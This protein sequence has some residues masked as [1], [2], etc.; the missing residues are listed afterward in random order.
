MKNN[1]TLLRTSAFV[2]LLTALSFCT[3]AQKRQPKF[4]TKPFTNKVFI[5]ERGQFAQRA[6]EQGIPFLEKVMY[7]VENGEFYTY[8]N[9][10]GITFRFA[11]YKPIERDEEEDA[12]EEREENHEESEEEE[13]EK[14]KFERVWHTVNLKFVNANPLTEVVAAEKVKEYYNYAGYTNNAQYN[15]V[16][17]YKKIKFGNIYPGVDAEFELPAEGGIKYQFI[18]KPGVTIPQIA[19]ELT[20]NDGLAIDEKGNLLINSVFGNLTDHA[21]MAYTALSHTPVLVKYGVQRNRVNFQ[22]STP[23]ISSP[24][25]I[26]IDPWI[27]ATAFPATNSAFDIQEDAAGNVFVQG[28]TSNYQVQKYSP[29]GV[30]IWTYVT[31]S[32]FL[33]DIAVDNPGNVYIVGGYSPGKRQKLDPNG[34]QQWQFSGLSE[35]WRL[36]FDYS[37]TT[38][39]VGG[40]FVN[41]AGNNVGRFD[42][43]TGAISNEIVYGEET[44]GIATDCNG[45]MFSLHVTFGYSG[46][47]ASNLLR[48]TNANFT[49]AGSVVDGFLLAE[50][51]TATGYAPNPLY[52]SSIYQGINA[53]AVMGSYV[54][55]F[56]GAS[57][58]RFNKTTLAFINSVAVP[59][60]SVMMCSG[61]AADYCGNIYT[62]SLNGIVKFDSALTYQQ[63]IAAP[64]VIYDILLSNAGEL[65]V[66]GAGFLGNFNITCI[67]PAALSATTNTGC[68]GAGPVTIAASGGLGPYTYLWQPN[69]ETT[70]SITNAPAGTYSYEVK[71]VFCNSY[72]DTL[73]VTARPVAVFGG[74]STGSGGA[75]ANS[76]CAADIIQFTDNSTVSSGTIVSR[77]WNFGDGSP[78]DVTQNP[79]HAYSLPGTYTVTLIVTSNTGCADTSTVPVT[80][81]PLPVADFSVPSFCPGVQGT[82]T[83]Q[84]AISSGSITSYSW[85]F[86]DGSASS[87]LQS[88]AHTYSQ[89]NT[90]NVSLSVTSNN[91]C[92]HDTTKAVTVSA[93]PLAAFSA[94]GGCI[95][96]ATALT[97]LSTVTSPSTISSWAWDIDNNGTTDYST[98]SA[99]HTFPT[100]GTY[101]VLLTV[102]SSAG[103]TDDTLVALTF[104]PTVTA[105]FNTAN[106]CQNAPAVFTD[107]STGGVASWN[108]DFNDGS[109]SSSQ[110]PSHLFSTAG[111]Y[112]VQLLVTSGL[113]CTDSI[114]KQLTVYPTPVIDFSTTPANGCVPLTVALNDLSS[115]ATGSIV[116]WNWQAGTIFSSAQQN[117]GFSFTTAGTYNITLTITS[118][119][120]CTDSLVK[121]L[122]A[123]AQPVVNFSTTPASGCVPFNVAL[124]DQSSIAAGTIVAW[125]W[126][127]GNLFSSTQQNAS[128]NFTAPGTYDVMLTVTSNQGC[129]DSLAKSIT[130][131]ASPVV[132]FSTTPASG[133]VP[134][135]V[136]FN[137]LSS[138]AT[139]SI[140]TWNW[141]AGTLFSSAQQNAGFSF[142]TAGTYNITL[143]ITSD[144]GCT[145]SLVKSVTAYAQPAADFS[146]TP[147]SGCVPFNVTLNDQSSIAAGTIVTWNWRAGNL[148]SS[149]Q[150]NAS[151]NF[152]SPGTNDVMLTVTSNQGCADS[153]TKS[154]TAYASPVVDFEA[155]PAQ[156]CV[157][158]DVP[159]NDLS[160]IA[161][162]SIVSWNWQ[163]E[164][165]F[166]SQQQNDNFSFTADGLYDVTLTVTSDMGCAT[167]LTRADFIAAYPNPVAEFAADP[168][169]TELVNPEIKFSDLSTGNPVQWNWQFGTGEGST[170]QNPSYSYRE[171][172]NFTVQLEIANQYGCTDSV[173]HTVDIFQTSTIF[174]P[175]VFTPNGDGNNDTWG[176]LAT[177]VKFFELKI[178]DRW[179]EKIFESNDINKQWDGTYRGKPLSPGVFV[180]TY[181]IVNLKNATRNMKGSLTLIK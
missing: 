157:P 52:G 74:T 88:P 38:L 83:N 101:N 105:D 161:A 47:A 34:V 81:Y 169:E 117:P 131:Y 68:E 107:Q 119:Q 50:A 118:D 99:T 27:T 154:I 25:G 86:G 151:F 130:A 160:T 143:T 116:T 7:G 181:T 115:I 129:I 113:G 39:T 26:V 100:A 133:C 176:V 31:A 79:Q 30:L 8:F 174:A 9:Q 147:A 90:F 70:A 12:R 91:G 121:S 124:N 61:I 29:A 28:S 178:F 46:V 58:R 10:T 135:T 24:E 122:D 72:L 80:V 42:T 171:V 155:I 82:F 77:V 134:L 149:T 153:L 125:N 158:L 11:E 170:L 97:D 94:T 73:T 76:A 146:T 106:V 102:V 172:G 126:Q 49:P 23:Q 168:W 148:F 22:F 141:Q 54:Y 152:T 84:S 57:V 35:E 109:F 127:A 75:G 111:T 20:G 110:N 108:W 103:C 66:C 104:F 177:N 162:G 44:R 6:A 78:V 123:Y 56:D 19:F 65:L 96:G 18:V 166:T 165:L 67:T 98:A 1:F 93:S 45:D 15:F 59:N 138:I 167:T 95:S 51:E 33:G 139:G 150:Q 144:Q 128:F 14:Q 175:N 3:Y 142:T 114:S 21:P 17:A 36:A 5:E 132:D 16:P 62:G 69:G 140:A 180:Y 71:D 2:M 85:N 40:Y 13:R 164:N 32:I 4:V 136:A 137:D 163:I 64:G 179:G 92:V 173:T 43:S 48:K 120:G 41:P 159:I 37:K 55:A 156:G 145:D 89:S 63:T 87:T 53:L 112:T 60:G